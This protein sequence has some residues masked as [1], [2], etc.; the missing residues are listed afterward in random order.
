M[1]ETTAN[2]ATDG[3]SPAA[4]GVSTTTTTTHRPSLDQF[5]AQ[6]RAWLGERLAPRDPRGDTLWGE[7]SDSVAVFHHLTCAEEDALDREARAWQRAKLADGWGAITWPERFGGRALPS[8][9]ERSFAEEEARF[10]APK[11]HE[12]FN[13][14]LHLMAP[15]VEAFGTEEQKDRFIPP[16]L[17]A[18]L[19]CC[20]L[21]SEPNAGSDLASLSCRATLSDG[22]WVIDGQKVW[23]SGA[24]LADYGLLIARS[25]PDAL[26]HHGMTAFLVPLDVEGIEIRP[27]RQMTGGASFYEVFLTDVHLD[28]AH[29]LGEVGDG[30]KVALGTLAFERN[31]S[32]DAAGRPGGSFAQVQALARHLQKTADPIVRQQLAMLYTRSRLTE[33]SGLRVR[34]ALRAGQDPGP[35][36]SVGKLFWTQTL[37]YTSSVVSHLLGPRLVAD[38][39]EWGTYAWAEHV[40]GAPGYR[41]AGGSDEIQRNIIGEKV[42]G[43]PREPRP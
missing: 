22:G 38:S 10:A 20:Q 28:D 18:D 43:L 26:K 31:V 41:I 15:A 30:W 27:I 39:G 19:L 7:G 4:R 24:R 16:F 6:A 25:D 23:T 13:A 36:G 8:V 40:L 17:R 34:G 37:T 3:L 1:I 9:Y 14:T 5:R 29:R 21:F 42:L 12:A 32:G 33:L 35:L 11:G 2:G